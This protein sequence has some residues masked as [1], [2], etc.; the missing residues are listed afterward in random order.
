M[1]VNLL[2]LVVMF[3]FCLL[4]AACP[5]NLTNN[6]LNEEEY[7]YIDSCYFNAKT[8]NDPW[9]FNGFEV[10][11]AHSGNLISRTNKGNPFGITYKA[12]FPAQVK[13]RNVKLVVDAFLRSSDTNHCGQFVVAVNKGDKTLFYTGLSNAKFIHQNNEW[14]HVVD[15]IVLPMNL[16]QAS[17]NTLSVYLYNNDEKSTID[18]DDVLIKFYDFKIPSYLPSIPAVSAEKP[19][20][21]TLIKNSFYQIAFDEKQAMINIS[22]KENF[23]LTKQAVYSLEYKLQRT[24]KSSKSIVL[25]Q[26]K[27]LG[28][29]DSSISF[30]IAGNE[31]EV[32]VDF[33]LLGDSPKLKIKSRTLFKKSVFIVREALVFDMNTAISEVYRKNRMVD[34]SHFQNEYWL[35]KEGVKFGKGN[36]SLYFYH[37][38]QISSAQ[39]DA[40][41][42]RLV[43]NLDYAFDHLLMH[44]PVRKDTLKG[45]KEDRS[46]NWCVKGSSASSSFEFFCGE[47]AA[48]IPRFMKNPHGYIAAFIFTEH[49]DYTDLRTQYA[50]NYGS[51]EIQDYNKATG[52]FAKHK[53]PVTKS[54]FYNNPEN[55]NNSAFNK[56]FTTPHCALKST[57]DFE[58]FI[59]DLFQHGYEIT[60]HTPDQNTTTPKNL[61]EAIRYFSGK[62]NSRTWIDHGYDN[63]EKDNREDFVCDGLIKQSP[64]YALDL[65]K[66][67]NTRYFWNCYTEDSALFPYAFNCN[68]KAIYHGFGD[69]LPTPDYWAH[70]AIATGVYSWPSNQLLFNKDAGLWGFFFDDDRINDLVQSQ[71]ILVNHC[72]PS[73]IDPGTGFFYLNEKGKYVITPEFDKT[74]EKLA[75]FRDQNVLNT[76][77]IKQFMDYQI[78]LE[79][80]EYQMVSKGK[81]KIVNHNSTAVKGLSMAINAK[82]VVVSG[83]QIKT[84]QHHKDILFWF[85]LAPHES[86]DITY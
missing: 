14:S 82:E 28:T 17:E 46:N 6:N 4:F 5:T 72:Y 86:V 63:G 51:E 13:G 21:K 3:L 20:Y 59:D 19:S 68:L 11:D 84:K 8:G 73:R 41:K 22:N 81:I 76:T 1:K 55:T 24:E 10:N 32:F 52:G 15:T 40:N 60:L 53:I 2:F 85:D 37:N 16:T 61:E 27:L 38:P 30:K 45:I 77:T 67:Y 23:S 36:Q 34:Q 26:W 48:S 75:S 56:D 64:Y 57:P 42:N 50:V 43:V 31:V 83:K 62:Y 33:V 80:V 58:K 65:W 7:L 70:K 35:D 9:S 79:N 39:I 74:L 29:S 44:F 12:N 18:A 49:A 78:A 25:D 47:D 71:E 69:L 66:K 54:V